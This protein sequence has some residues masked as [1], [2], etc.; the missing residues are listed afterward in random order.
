MSGL[1][2]TFNIAKRGM[3]VQQKSIDVTSHNI[4]NSNTVGYSRQ[5][6]KIETSR[7]FG[8]T[9]MGSSVQAG[10]LGTGSQIQAIERVRDSF[11]DFQVRGENAILA[12]YDM[13][14]NYLYEVESVFNEP[15]DTGLSTLMGKFFDSFQ[16]LSKQPNSSNSRTVVAQQSAALA[17]ALNATYTKLENLKSNSQDMLKS[18]VT[19]VNSTLE[20]LDR[21]NQEIIS[22][23]VSG[24]TPNDLMDKRDL[25]LDELSYK[26]GIQVDKKEFNGIDVKPNETG[27]MKASLLVNSRP[28]GDVARFSYV[29]NVEQ[30]RNDLSGKTYIVTYYK[31]GDM[32]SENNRQTLKIS[33]I[34]EEKAK[35]IQDNRIIW[36]DKTGQAARGDGY[37]IRNG[38][39]VT[40]SELMLFKPETG[41][42]N[43]LV[44]VQSDIE[45]YMNQLDKL[46]KSL[47]FSVNA[48]H[49]G[50][51][52]PLNNTVG[53]DKDYLPFFVNKD[54]AKYRTNGLL[55]NLDETLKGEEEINAKNISMNT[56]ILEDVMKMKT[57][58]HDDLFAYTH[59]NNIDGDGDGARAL[60]IAQLRD[61]LIRIQ[62]INET[63]VSR[64]DM[65][66]KFKGGNSLS[67]NGLKIENSTSGMKMDSYF[68]D[69]IDRLGVQ[70][71]EANR[72]VTNQE[73]LL[74]SIEES[75]ASVS[76]VNLDEEMANLV[77]FQHAYNANAKIIS[78][79]DELLDVIINNLK[80]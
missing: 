48:I 50:I 72:M 19:E 42:I 49:S 22:V 16:E 3:N 41:S 39:T 11:L 14:S 25:L 4:A 18:T 15:S 2:S 29:T 28:N 56:E 55:S 45:D 71:Q 13:R 7:P 1:F 38:D 12:K 51:E 59:E 43:G 79:V 44:S 27:N 52:D 64:K 66:D 32:D 6:A 9:S 30:D 37:P 47:A 17:D 61:S 65:F 73:D 62:D 63:V 23:T 8:G 54:V 5:R 70:A 53:A 68:K 80:R 31:N 46:A 21:V 67:N 40:Y 74:Y 26:F 60:S 75:R 34:T 20:Q 10:Q 36:A 77:Q 35:E 78:T 24:N 58:T 57:R 76:G 69:T 33:G